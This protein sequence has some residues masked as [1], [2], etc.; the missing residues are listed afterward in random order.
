MI[1]E[2]LKNFREKLEK[3][4]LETIKILAQPIKNGQTL[5]ITQSKFLGKPYIPTHKNYPMCTDG[6]PM[7]MFAQFN[8]AKIPEIENYPT[9]GILQFFIHPKNWNDT[10]EYKI[11]FHENDKEDYHTN[12]DFLIPSLYEEC[13][14]YCEHELTFK[15]EIEFGG[16]QDFNFNSRF[17]VDFPDLTEIEKEEITDSFSAGGHK[18][19]GYATFTQEDPRMYEEHIKDTVLLFQIDTDEQIMFGDA[20]IAN[21]FININDLRNKNFNNAYFNWDCC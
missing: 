11:L 14:I 7:I 9:S 5:T 20:G 19:G 3:Y 15:K 8:F 13:P 10:E 1:P 4:K 2:F 12:F 17:D 18:I 21:V 16:R 6:T